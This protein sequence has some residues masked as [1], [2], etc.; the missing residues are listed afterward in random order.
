MAEDIKFGVGA[1][2]GPFRRTM[3]GLSTTAK[4]AGNRAGKEFTKSFNNFVN[5]F[6]GVG[7]IIGM[8]R[9]I[10][11]LGKQAEKLKLDSV[12]TGISTDRLQA[13]D[14]LSQKLGSLFDNLD[15]EAQKAFADRLIESG[16]IAVKTARQLDVLAKAQKDLEQAQ[17]DLESVKTTSVS[18]FITSW[19]WISKQIAKGINFA[20]GKTP[21]MAKAP[22]SVT[23]RGAP[24]PPRAASSGSIFEAFAK[25]IGDAK[26]KPASR[27]MTR[28]GGF[29]T[30][31]DNLQRMGLF[32]GGAGNPAI[33]IAR[34]Q[35]NLLKQIHQEQR[36]MV[37]ALNE[38]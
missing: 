5:R 22:A 13:M 21:T 4:S 24:T 31:V 26:N 12:I 28:T 34:E 37:A 3:A 36:R 20:Q 25:E 23:K 18:D 32:V 19:N 33:T 38:L 2:A 29:Q 16:E 15:E 17:R 27:P 30:P 1:D 7:A 35:V 11:A 10:G 8:A 6:L 9:S 14:L